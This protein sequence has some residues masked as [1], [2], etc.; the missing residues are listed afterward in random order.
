M[1]DIL[2]IDVPS[3]YV[4]RTDASLFVAQIVR[5]ANEMSSTDNATP[6][7]KSFNN[8]NKTNKDMNKQLVQKLVKDYN[9]YLKED[10]LVYILIETNNNTIYNC[11]DKV[12]YGDIGIVFIDEDGKVLTL[13]YEN[14]VGVKVRVI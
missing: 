4:S 1:I 6:T 10:E 5:T 7:N 13:P 2:Y 9:N 12:A 14:I 11:Y 3:E 8:N